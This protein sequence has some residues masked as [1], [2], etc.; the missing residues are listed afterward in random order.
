MGQFALRWER[1]GDR[2]AVCNQVVVSN[3]W[4][5]MWRLR[6]GVEGIEGRAGVDDEWYQGG[7]QG[8]T[9]VGGKLKKWRNTFFHPQQ[10]WFDNRSLLSLCQWSTAAA[11]MR[12][13]WFISDPLILLRAT[14]NPFIIEKREQLQDLLIYRNRQGQSRLMNCFSELPVT[15]YNNLTNFGRSNP[16]IS[17]ALDCISWNA[18]RWWERYSF[19]FSE[20]LST[21]DSLWLKSFSR[22]N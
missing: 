17:S 14:V 13:D 10:V 7:F 21:S 20:L 8:A 5:G 3:E 4:R 12:G 19:P 2:R 11:M 16:P 9:V 1:R 18:T 15:D 22:S 6:T